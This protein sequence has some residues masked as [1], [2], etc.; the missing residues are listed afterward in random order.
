MASETDTN[1]ILL[2]WTLKKKR[3]KRRVCVLFFSLLLTATAYLSHCFRAVYFLLTSLSLF[4]FLVSVS[5]AHHCWEHVKQWSTPCC[6]WSPWYLLLSFLLFSLL[7]SQ[8]F[9]KAESVVT[10][11]S[12]LGQEN[13]EGKWWCLTC[14]FP[15]FYHKPWFLMAGILWWHL[16]PALF[17]VAP[18]DQV[19]LPGYFPNEAWEIM[20][21]LWGRGYRKLT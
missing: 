21:G 2:L 20:G 11:I 3:L 19:T 14:N 17:V 16:F 12:L 10:F 15:L 18:G 8:S 1:H 13:S 9:P 7:L 6:L 5:A 4:M